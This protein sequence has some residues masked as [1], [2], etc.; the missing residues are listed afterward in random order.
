LWFELSA[1]GL[2]PATALCSKQ[3][4]IVDTINRWSADHHGQSYNPDTATAAALARSRFGLAPVRSPLLRG[5]FLF[6]G[7]HEM[8]Q[9]PRFPPSEDGHGSR[10]WGCPIRRSWDQG[11]QAAPPRISSLCH[12]LHRHAAPRHPPYAH[13]VFPAEVHDVM[14]DVLIGRGFLPLYNRVRGDVGGIPPRPLSPE[15]V[16][17]RKTLSRTK[18]SFFNTMHLERYTKTL[19]AE[20]GR[21]NHQPTRRVRFI[22]HRS[23]F[24]VRGAFTPEV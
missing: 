2:S 18:R 8:V 3:L 19:K 14:L 22:V 15:T 24:I 20:R 16:K 11:L 21:L 13:C 4:C 5:Y 10:P 7:V 23:S 1:T 9:F 6:L 12:V 17:S